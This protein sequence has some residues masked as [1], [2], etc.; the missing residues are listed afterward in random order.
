MSERPL[1]RST[2]GRA[3][4]SHLRKHLPPS[5]YESCVRQWNTL[6]RTRKTS[7]RPSSE[8]SNG[9]GHPR[10]SVPPHFASRSPFEQGLFG[11]L[12]EGLPPD[13]FEEFLRKW[14]AM[15]A[16]RAKRTRPSR[17]G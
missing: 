15:R 17:D 5:E 10:R 9:S 11:R 2:F 13:D 3:L 6:Y 4:F 1:V 14:D 8:S 12:R 16:E 7:S